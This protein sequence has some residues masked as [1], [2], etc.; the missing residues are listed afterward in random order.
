MTPRFP[1]LAFVS[2]CALLTGCASTPYEA[3]QVAATPTS[4]ALKKLPRKAGEPV[5]VS[6]YE[7]RSS[8]S[9]V[10]ARGATDM[11]KTALV[12][13]GQFRVVE[14]S[15]INDG[16]IREKQLNAQ[17][18][19]SGRSAQQP[20]RDARYLFEGAVTEANATENQRSGAINVGGLEIGGGSNQDTI[21]IDVR[22]VDVAS[23]DIVDSITVRK[24]LQS[25]NASV[26]LS[27]I[28]I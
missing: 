10:S 23:G 21:A 13:S 5:A 28:H 24:A 19:S 12:Q 16:V 18:M 17:G 8:V 15:R 1:L 7:F 26:G 11:F 9:E 3:P 4:Q 25:D 22:I 6:I 2:A 14:R 20:L 27:L